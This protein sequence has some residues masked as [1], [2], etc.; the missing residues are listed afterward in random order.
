MQ[1]RGTAKLQSALLSHSMN[2]DRGVLFHV[3]KASI[4]RSSELVWRTTAQR[5]YRWQA[6]Y[7]K[8]C[9]PNFVIA[10]AKTFDMKRY[11]TVT[12][13]ALSRHHLTG[14]SRKR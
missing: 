7:Q 9:V 12:R 14:K 13:G 2:L 4:T 11:M 5:F 10:E 1:K 8:S 3:Q 6:I